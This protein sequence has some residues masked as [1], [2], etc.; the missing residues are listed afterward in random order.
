[1]LDL[2]W[3]RCERLFLELCVLLIAGCYVKRL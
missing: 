1:M 2:D 3:G